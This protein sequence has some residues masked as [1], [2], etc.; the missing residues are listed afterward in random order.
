MAESPENW[1]LSERLTDAEAI[2]FWLD[3]GVVLATGQS[4][5]H[6]LWREQRAQSSQSRLLRSRR[7]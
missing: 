7:R 2:V 4:D 1:L 5:F 6:R 3:A